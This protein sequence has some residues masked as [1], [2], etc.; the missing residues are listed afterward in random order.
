VKIVAPSR[1]MREA[2]EVLDPVREEIVVIGAVAVQVALDGH[3]AMLT[4]T[5]DLDAGV[6]T[7]AVPRVVARLQECGLERSEL[8]HERSFTWVKGDL[9]VQLL[10]PF[11]PFPKGPAQG[12]PVN[13]IISELTEH[14]VLVAFADEPGRGRFWAASPAA[15]VALKAA[16]F[17]RTRAT[18]ENVD[19]DF[20]DVMLL[21]DHLGPEIAQEVAPPSPMHSRVKQA[22]EQLLEDN[23]VA[24]AA[25]ELVQTGHQS[26]QRAAAEA[27]RRAAQRALRRLERTA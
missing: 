24:A 17:G 10:R 5:R 21:L 20:S 9:K 2:A 16:A 22:A 25:R 6:A 14:R 3:D 15:L 27:V 12:L 1:L 23:A 18:G 19:R 26:S 7:D 13:N 11:H 8:S 4:P